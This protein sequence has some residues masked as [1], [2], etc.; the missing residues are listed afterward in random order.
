MP[1]TEQHE[2]CL[3]TGALGSGK[4]TLLNRLLQCRELSGSMVLINEFGDIGLD[5][6]IVREIKEDV[7][8]LSSGCLCCSL[9]GDLRDEL[10]AIVE[11]PG[12]GRDQDHGTNNY[13]DHRAG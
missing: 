13:R 2:V 1:A 8:L 10:T 4:T 11:S 9:K 6:E 7:L 3:I 5:H 12:R